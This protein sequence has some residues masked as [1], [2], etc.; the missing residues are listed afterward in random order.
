MCVCVSLSCL[1]PEDVRKGIRSL[2]IGATGDCELLLCAC[3][4]WSPGTV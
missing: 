1:V 2:G 4:E 3:W